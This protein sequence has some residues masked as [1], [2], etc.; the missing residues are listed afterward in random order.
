MDLVITFTD[1]SNSFACGAEYGRLLAKFEKGEMVV[2]N[3]G[4]PVH[5]Q[6]K[7]VLIST[8]SHFGYTPIFGE[9]YYSEWVDFRAVKNDNLN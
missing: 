7:K 8:C 4:F 2:E 5:L 3:N 6:N 1:A 9:V